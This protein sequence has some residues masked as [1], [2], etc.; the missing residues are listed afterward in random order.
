[1]TK[2]DVA[3]TI[4]INQLAGYDARRKYTAK[5]Q[6]ELFGWVPFGRKTVRFDCDGQGQAIMT[7]RDCTGDTVESDM[8]FEQIAS[9]K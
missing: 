9:R 4:E 7:T 3:A 6:R 8:S 2:Y 1:M 5:E